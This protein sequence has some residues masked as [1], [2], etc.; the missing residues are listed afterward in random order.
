MVTNAVSVSIGIPFFNAGP[1]LADALRSV[2]A[3][4]YKDWELLLVDDGSSDGSV[5]IARALRDSRVR[6]VSDGVNR[7]LPDR[8][9]QI[10]ALAQG[11]YLA[12]MDA[13]DLMHPERLEKEVRFLEAN[14][15]VDLVDTATFTLDE[16]NE[17][18]GVRGDGPLN[19]DRR[20]IL[21]S[22]LLIHP[23]VMGR[24]SWFRDNPYDA[25]FIRAEDQELWVRTCSKT[26][27]G[28]LQ[29]PLFFYRE[30]LAGN[31][32]NY[33]RTQKTLR[34][35][36]HVYGPDLIGHTGT[37]LHVARSYT[38]T[39][40]YWMYTCVG[41]QGRLIRARTRP[42]TAA[43]AMAAGA[44]I[45]V[46]LQTHLP[47]VDRVSHEQTTGSVCHSEPS[48]PACLHGLA[49]AEL[50]RRSGGVCAGPGM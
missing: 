11:K 10:A 31:L 4:T 7:R 8:L 26:V 13:D 25:R 45:R 20:A 12:R 5:E 17:L 47:T 14:P 19:C 43:E 46:I 28:R 1:T 6:L 23:T 24:T 27:F 44:A 2:F 3:Q 39:W 37:A 34:K 42:L 40:T 35:I 36:F 30:S 38:K 33:L 18:L 22:G 16:N 21:K 32:Q 48:S 29:E 9:N 41:Q 50:S 15:R 49:D